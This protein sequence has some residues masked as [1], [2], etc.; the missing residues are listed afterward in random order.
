MATATGWRQGI[1]APG[2]QPP[3]PT[4]A[5]LNQKRMV[6]GLDRPGWIRLPSAC[7]LSA[8]KPWRC[9]AVPAAGLQVIVVGLRSLIASLVAQH[10]AEALR[11]R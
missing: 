2:R 1:K 3:V 9:L 5:P 11:G 8:D 4:P 7:S 6:T 10:R